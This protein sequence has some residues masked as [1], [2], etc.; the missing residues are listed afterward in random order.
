MEKLKRV[1]SANAT[2]VVLICL[3]VFFTI[4]SP[5]F[6]T[7]KNMITVLRQVSVNGICAVGLAIEVDKGRG[8]VVLVIG[9]RHTQVV[10]SGGELGQVECGVVA[11]ERATQGV[12][13]FA[14]QPIDE[15]KR[16]AG[17]VGGVGC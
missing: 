13:L 15:L 8:V 10:M 2:W 6:M 11:G 12:N 17:G 16:A 9:Q 5:N 7:V 4:L 1:L 14:C 3:M